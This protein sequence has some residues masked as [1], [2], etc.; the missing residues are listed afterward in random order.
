MSKSPAFQTSVYPPALSTTIILALCFLALPTR[1]FAHPEIEAQLAHISS[2]IARQ[3]GSAE[4]YL[5]R[6]HLYRTHRDWEKGL[7]DFRQA[8]KLDPDLHQAE[9]AIGR[10]YLEADKPKRAL[11]QIE[12]FLKLQSGDADGLILRGRAQGKLGA[13]EKAAADF[14]TALPKLRRPT[15]ELF[16]ERAQILIDGGEK[17]HQR[18]LLGLAEGIERLGDL[19][20]LHKFAAQLEVK[21]GQPEAALLRIRSLLEKTKGQLTWRILEAELLESSQQIEEARASYQKALAKLSSLPPHRR[22]T[23]V[24]TETEKSIRKALA[25]ISAE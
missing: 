1:G 19:Y 24:I 18:A 12:R 10:L 15:P 21:A 4:L 7:A 2:E 9:R 14:D 13:T 11:P 20:T 6:G 25:E 23:P 16:F 22:R 8:V 5:Q 3:P 17:Y